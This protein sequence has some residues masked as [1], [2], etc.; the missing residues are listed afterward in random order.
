MSTPKKYNGKKHNLLAISILSSGLGKASIAAKVGITKQGIQRWIDLYP[1]F[2]EAVEIGMMQ[3]ASYYE[4]KMNSLAIGELEN[5][6]Y[7]QMRYCA[8]NIHRDYFR[9]SA[10]QVE[11]KI[12]ASVV[13]SIS[14]DFG[15]EDNETKDQSNL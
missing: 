11:S 1:E 13:P 6:H 10:T 8:Q 2:A 12:E 15:K 5:G 7:S 3:G 9:E 4:K 14:I